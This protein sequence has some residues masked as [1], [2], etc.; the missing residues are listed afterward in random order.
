MKQR[1]LQEER[2]REHEQQQRLREIE[3]EKRRKRNQF[4]YRVK[5]LKSK[6]PSIN[7][8]GVEE[9][10]ENSRNRYYESDK[11]NAIH[12]LDDIEARIKEYENIKRELKEIGVKINKLTERLAEGDIDSNTYTRALN[13]LE[14]L[15]LTFALQSKFC[16]FF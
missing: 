15:N 2:R 16:F 13:D 14:A 7:L 3:E 6:Y 5:E 4:H 8:K 10:F 1:R 12:L 9:L 11:E